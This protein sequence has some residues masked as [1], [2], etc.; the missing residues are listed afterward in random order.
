MLYKA[1]LSSAVR[2]AAGRSLAAT[3]WRFTTAGDRKPT[4]TAFSPAASLTLG[5]GT[6]TGYKFSL[7]GALTA[8]KHATLA[9]AKAVAT[10]L[11]RTIANQ[12]GT[13][14]YVASGTW[15][16]YWLRESAAVTLGSGATASIGTAQ[17]FSPAARVGV[18]KGTHTGYTFTAGGAMTGARTVSTPYRTADSSELRAFPGQTGL[19]FRMTS[20]AFKGYWLRSSNV[21]F[22]A[23]GG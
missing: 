1:S 21:V 7:T 2:G 10:S 16:G 5:V 12:A 3:Y 15:K 23:S 11:K 17:V 13:W 20:G 8:S 6:N 19:W 9:S 4:I 22:L 18:R 14:Y